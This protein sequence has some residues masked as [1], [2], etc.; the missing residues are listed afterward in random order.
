MKKRDGFAFSLAKKLLGNIEGER[1]HRA[2]AHLS[3]RRF[4]EKLSGTTNCFEPT[5]CQG[6][7]LSYAQ[8]DSPGTPPNQRIYVPKIF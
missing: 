1:Y 3:S 6:T 8:D 2:H 4:W 5:K 7:Q